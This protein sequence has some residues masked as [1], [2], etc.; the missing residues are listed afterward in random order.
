MIQQQSNAISC[1]KYCNIYY[2]IAF[3]FFPATTEIQ[4]DRQREILMTKYIIHVFRPAKRKGEAQ[5]L[6]LPPR[7]TIHYCFLNETT[8]WHMHQ[9]ICAAARLLPLS[10][11]HHHLGFSAL[12]PCVCVCVSVGLTLSVV[13]RVPSHKFKVRETQKKFD[14]SVQHTARCPRSLCAAQNKSIG[15]SFLPRKI[16]LYINIAVFCPFLPKYRV[17]FRGSG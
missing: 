17:D 9:S 10:S 4:L 3:K 1:I 5:S 13:T 11:T 2:I 16:E 12:F 7:S 15:V 8:A 14:W 6:L